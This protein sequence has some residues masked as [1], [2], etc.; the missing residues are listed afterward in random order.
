[1]TIHKLSLWQR[2]IVPAVIGGL[3]C[4]ALEVT[5]IDRGHWLPPL[6]DIAVMVLVTWAAAADVT[7]L[8]V[9]N[10]L[11]YPAFLL[12]CS[13]G[14]AVSTL[15]EWLPVSALQTLGAIGLPECLV[16]AA[17]CFAVMLVI[18]SLAGRGGGD[19]KLATAVGAF[20]G[21]RP[22]LQI[23]VLTHVFAA[24]S[25]FVWLSV[26]CGLL[27]TVSIL[28]RQIGQL[29]LP[30]WVCP[31]RPEEQSLMGRPIPLA[32]FLAIA[33]IVTLCGVKVL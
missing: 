20:V 21:L 22:G 24:V 2:R 7:N 4:I 12:A 11:T 30:N 14:V 26:Q 18:W 25:A 10:R 23:I 17:A 16:G 15:G 9:P 1:M 8:R 3:G 31:A 32:A 28:L 6:V 29:L 33:C 13:L 19:V 5:A 27:R